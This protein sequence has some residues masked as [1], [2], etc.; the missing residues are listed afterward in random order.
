MVSTE[1]LEAILPLYNIPAVKVYL[2]NRLECV[3]SFSF[4][5]SDENDFLLFFLLTI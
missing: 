1:M 2:P 4:L 3:P 5:F